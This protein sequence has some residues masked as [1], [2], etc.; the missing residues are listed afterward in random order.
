MDVF[1]AGAGWITPL[2]AG[3][4][5]VWNAIAAGTPAPVRELAGPP[6]RKPHRAALIPPKLA[7][8][9]ARNPR[10]RRASN[11]SLFAATA[12][13]AAMRDAG[14]DPAQPG[15]CAIV[16]AVSDGGVIYTRRFYDQVVREGS[17][18]PLLF[19]ETVYNAPAS[20]VAAILGIDGITYTLA[21]DASAGL[22]AL[23]LGAELI[24][25]GQ[26]DHCIVA[27]AEEA[28]WILGEAYSQW[29]LASTRGALIAD[30]AAAVVLSRA[31]RY[32]LDCVTP[33]VPF[34]K[35]AAASASLSAALD[36]LP[37]VRPARIISSANGTFIDRAERLALEPRFPGLPV[38]RPKLSLG[39]AFGASA[40]MQVICAMRSLDAAGAA[41][42][43]VIGL[44]HQAAAALISIPR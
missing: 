32:R 14:L 19:P 24:A 26:A 30:G 35:Q 18:S 16:F 33:G 40:L 42:A 25:S 5:E 13:L 38:L 39:D 29:G 21:G 4:D 43:A 22:A 11:I 27:G 10:L 31:G 41:L 6:G 20:H 15:R 37:D 3:L 9:V 23:R 8:A 7:D 36:Q 28:D 1:I 34:F 12:V 44:N 17:G 2:G